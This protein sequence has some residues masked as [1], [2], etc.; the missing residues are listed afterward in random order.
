[1]MIHQAGGDERAPARWPD[2]QM[3]VPAHGKVGMAEGGGGAG[4]KE[5]TPPVGG[6]C[7][8]QAI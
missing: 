4:K 1:M 6:V 7:A 8:G 2:L 3:G 5:R